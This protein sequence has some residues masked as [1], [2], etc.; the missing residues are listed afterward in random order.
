MDIQHFQ[1]IRIFIDWLKD[2]DLQMEKMWYRLKKI[3][4]NYFQKKIGTN[5]IFKLFIMEE[6]IVKREIAMEFLVK[7]VVLVILTEKNHSKQKKLNVKILGIGNA[8]VDVL[9]KVEDSFLYKNNL[10]KG[11]MK[12]IF[13]EKLEDEV[14]VGSGIVVLAGL[15]TFWR[16][17]IKKQ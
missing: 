4:K 15:F 10:T 16:E 13:D 5:F 3:L 14:L 11:T 6:N 8:I 12:L 7:F 9:C 17:H 1:W 2:G